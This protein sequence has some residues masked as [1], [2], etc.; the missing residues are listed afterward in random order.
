MPFREIIAEIDT[1]PINTSDRQNT[2]LAVT[3]QVVV[4]FKQ[5][6]GMSQR[7]IAQS[8]GFRLQPARPESL[9]ATA[10][11]PALWPT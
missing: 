4:W 8:V 6:K 2:V 11:R 5:F 10:S 3:K 1:N 9:L 7:T